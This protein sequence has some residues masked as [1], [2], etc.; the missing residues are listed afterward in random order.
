MQ[1]LINSNLGTENDDNVD[2][3]ENEQNQDENK[4]KKKK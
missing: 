2:E 4:T 1:Q 3:A